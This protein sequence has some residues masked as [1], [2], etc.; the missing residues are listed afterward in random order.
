[1]P[2]AFTE[3][4]AYF[5]ALALAGAALWLVAHPYRG[6]YQDANLYTLMALRWLDSAAYARDPFFMFGSQDAFSLFSPLHGSLIKILGVSDASRVLVLAGGVS[7]LGASWLVAKR[8]FSNPFP[9]GAFFLCCAVLSLSYSPAGSTF[10]LSESFA[11]AR[12]IS[13][14]LGI[15]AVALGTNKPLAWL[16]ALVATALHPLL[17]VWPLLFL[18]SAGY[19]DRKLAGLAV[20][21]IGFFLLAAFLGKDSFFHPVAAERFN[22]LRDSTLDLLVTGEG[23]NN[24]LFLLTA[25][26]LGG[27]Y[28]SQG[29]RRAYLLIALLS[30]SAYLLSLIVSLFYPIEFLLQVQPWRAMWLATFFGLAAMVDVAWAIRRGRP[31]G[32]FYVLLVGAVLLVCKPFAGGLLLLGYVLLR[33]FP[34]LGL[35]PPSFSVS[36]LLVTVAVA[37][38]ALPAWISDVQLEGESLSLFGWTNFETLRGVV[39]GSGYGVGPLL[40]VAALLNARW[41]RWLL[42]LLIP[43]LIWASMRWDTRATPTRLWEESIRVPAPKVIPGLQPGQTVYWPNNLVQVWFSL[44]IAGYVGEYHLSGLVFSA[45][46]TDL[47]IAR[48]RR[49][50]VASV[51]QEPL[52]GS[53]EYEAALTDFRLLHAERDFGRAKVG[54][55]LPDSITVGGVT[56][57]CA[58]PDLDW[59]IADFPTVPD[60]MG[61]GLKLPWEPGVRHYAYA[62][63]H[64]RSA[65]KYR[66]QS[67]P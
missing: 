50:A 10:V 58:D 25:L 3:N 15:A 28:G 43:V 61:V 51:I 27:Q 35:L 55:Y 37:L 30:A 66:I 53:A 8:L 54:N 5:L 6:L 31:S 62:C 67:T 63:H 33:Q 12:V 64:L 44:G 16:L 60:G 19:S 32:W 36:Q 38:L 57:L 18:F 47:V 48:L 7:W 52:G 26:L 39:G 2:Q 29:F 13:I 46:R 22:L 9:F 20:C 23:I 24:T 17:G 42:L 49:A 14:P 56:V 21:A 40:M 11:T 59:V 4:R 41:Q 34:I 65:A 1:M 45:E